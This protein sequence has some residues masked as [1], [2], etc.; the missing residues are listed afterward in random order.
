VTRADEIHVVAPG[1]AVW[2]AYEP[3]VKC[4]LHSTALGLDG[5]L[6]LID[7]IPLG[8]TAQ[9]ELEA[10]GQPALIVCTSGNHARAADSFR[11]KYRIPLAAHVGADLG[12]AVDLP[13]R[14]GARLL[15]AIEVCELPGAA[16]GELALF[17]PRG[18]VCVGDAL[19]N[20]PPEGFRPL[21][22]KYC[23][24]PKVLRGSLQKLLRWEFRVLTFAHGWPITTSARERLATLLS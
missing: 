8:E 20:L 16:S 23:A 24:D 17:H 19:I 15:D 7:P 9:A 2:Q 22:D 5:R 4:D 13:L 1:L 3:A 18:I 12:I 6:V 14:D 11:Q 21:P 10:T